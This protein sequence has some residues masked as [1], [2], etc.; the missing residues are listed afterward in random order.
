MFKGI[1]TASFWLL[2]ALAEV[3]GSCGEYENYK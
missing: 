2:G 3:P 1:S